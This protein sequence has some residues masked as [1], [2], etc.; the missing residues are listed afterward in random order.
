MSTL[1]PLA[2]TIFNIF[3]TPTKDI[4]ED[5]SNMS[6]DSDDLYDDCFVEYNSE[7]KEDDV[8]MQEEM[9]TNFSQLNLYD[10]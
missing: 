5:E 3:V 1:P 10:K 6:D 2:L 4:D 8:D 9:E 7:D